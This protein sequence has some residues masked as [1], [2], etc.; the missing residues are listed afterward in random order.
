MVV[1]ECSQDARMYGEGLVEYAKLLGEL[2]VF[3]QEK[4]RFGWLTGNS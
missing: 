2:E 1:F 4:R 3:V